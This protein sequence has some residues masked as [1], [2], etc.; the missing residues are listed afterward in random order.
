MKKHLFSLPF[1]SSMNEE[2][3]NKI[4]FPFLE[5][6]HP[7]LYDIYFT[8][9]VAP[10]I[11]DAMGQGRNI[12]DTEA[13]NQKVLNLMLDIQK[14]YN[15]R[16]SA[17]FNDITIDP[18]QKNMQIFIEN[19]KPYYEKGIVSVT[20][21][22]IHWMLSGEI[23]RAFP[24]LFVKN[25]ILRKVSKPQEYVD[26]VQAGFDAVNIDRANIRDRDNLKA[27]K[28]AYDVFKKPM[29]LLVNEGCRGN[30]P[31]MD[32][33][34]TINCSKEDK[35]PY[36][37]QEVAK[38]TCPLW[39]SI[40]PYYHLQVCNMPLHR[41]DFEEIIKYIQVLKLHGRSELNLLIESIEIVKRYANPKQKYILREQL[42]R[43]R[44]F[45]YDEAEISKWRA[46]TKNCKFE[47]WCCSTC[48]ELHNS[49]A[50]PSVV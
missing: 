31:T 26:Y 1:N 16:V 39:S 12:A 15:I 33:H 17:T 37:R 25:T 22:H 11:N 19:F 10:F 32:E 41:E 23:K 49:A 5:E 27:L 7:F 30:C 20:L 42:Q 14:R 46:Y 35:I 3:L 28:K 6:Y 13:D 18:T 47:C 9:S 36:F 45:N 43:F 44:K 34:Y 38:N 48:E 24:K 2:G 21:P 40:N 50:N 29:I 8:L 4:Y